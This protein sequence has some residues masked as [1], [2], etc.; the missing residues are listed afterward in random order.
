MPIFTV[1]LVKIY[2]I[3]YLWQSGF[4]AIRSENSVV[5]YSEC[6]RFARLY[7]KVG[8]IELLCPVY[9]RILIVYLI[10]SAY[11]CLSKGQSFGSRKR[12]ILFAQS[13]FCAQILNINRKCVIYLVICICERLAVH[14]K[15]SHFNIPV[16]K[17]YFHTGKNSGIL[18]VV[19]IYRLKAFFVFCVFY[20]GTVS[21]K[22]G[23]IDTRQ[24][25]L[26]C[27][28][29]KRIRAI[30]RGIETLSDESCETVSRIYRICVFADDVSFVHAII[31]GNVAC[32]IFGNLLINLLNAVIV[33]IPCITESDYESGS[34]SR[35]SS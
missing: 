10:N 6:F 17:A 11:S 3:T 14:H 34:I 2:V 9:T 26:V 4:N 25:P 18:A 12:Y 28:V 13:N 32:Y 19:D 16:Y 33:I 27:T 24:I 35:R 23:R 7:L 21:E 31:E 20:I 8:N 15:V 30:F 22:N 1:R 29:G 5:L